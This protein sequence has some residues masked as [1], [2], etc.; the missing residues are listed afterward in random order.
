[1]LVIPDQLAAA[2][3]TFDE[4]IE[5]VASAFRAFDDGKSRLFDVVRG[6][7]AR[8]EDFFGIKS[9][10]DGSIG[11][12][13]LK[14]GTYFPQAVDRGLPAHTS[15]IMLFD[16]DNAAPLALVGANRL[17][18]M[19]TAAANA[20]ATR[21]LAREESSTLGLIGSGHQAAFEAAAVT[22]V[23]PIRRILFWSP[24]RRS[25]SQFVAAVRSSTGI[26]ARPADLPEL[27]ATADVIVTATPSRA[28]LVRRSEIRAGTHISAMG[29]DADGKQ[30]LDPELVA[31]AKTYVDVP[32]QARLIGE[33]QHAC[34][35]GL[36]AEAALE[37]R[38]LGRL[39]NA[40]VAG[41]EHAEEITLFDSSGMALQ[42]IAV[43]H[44]VYRRA[45]Q[46]ADVVS[47]SLR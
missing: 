13:G 29:A 1:M 40:K 14:A 7:G 24:S 41:R 36:L 44:L 12:I 19:R 42:D 8:R 46:S 11:C 34:R 37:D 27:T 31:A 9:A 5:A 38:T 21:F 2:L 39:L 45:L 23:R 6:H 28:P 33:C 4:V 22:H 18:G 47:I 25:A 3:V 32:A 10:V 43:A 15:T 35:L 26:E 30:E 17:N 16:A 20:I